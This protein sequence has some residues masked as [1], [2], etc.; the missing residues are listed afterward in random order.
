[1]HHRGA[2][3]KNTPNNVLIIMNSN[4][5]T[6]LAKAIDYWKQ[7]DILLLDDILKLKMH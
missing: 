6:S 2:L 4:I 7:I 5:T 1:M 3:T